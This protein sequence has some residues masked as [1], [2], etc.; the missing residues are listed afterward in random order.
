MGESRVYGIGEEEF[1]LKVAKGEISRHELVH[2]FGRNALVPNSSWAGV[3]SGGTFNFLTAPTPVRIKA[4]GNVADNAGTTGVNQ[5][6]VEGLNS[7]GY[8]VSTTI[9]TNG[10]S[11]SLVTTKSFWRVNRLHGFQTGVYG[12]TNTG[13]IVIENSTGGTDLIQINAGSGQSEYGAYTIPKDKTGYLM[14]VTAEVDASKAADI[15]LITRADITSTVAPYCPLRQRLYFDGVKGE[16]NIRPKSPILSLAEL[17][18]IWFDANGGGAATE[19]SVDFE[20]VVVD[21]I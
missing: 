21:N 2:K 14:G 12:G 6:H 11:A 15:R 17:T 13:N 20:I 4:G 8:A 9:D 5:I 7:S 18:D 19:V 3:L 10:S 1:Y 16:S